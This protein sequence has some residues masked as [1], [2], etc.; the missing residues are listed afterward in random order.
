MEK[1]VGLATEALLTGDAEIAERVISGDAEID[2]AREEVE[3]TAFSLLSL[4]QPVARDLRV[5][6]S[7]LRMVSETYSSTVVGTDEIYD[8]DCD[9]FAPCALGASLNPETIPR[10]KCEAVVGSA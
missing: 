8:A 4:Q 3:E 5:V 7:A 6:V 2:R 1:A 9:I 10:L